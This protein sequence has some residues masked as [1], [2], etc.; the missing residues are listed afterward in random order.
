L[1]YIFEILASIDI[2]IGQTLYIS[3]IQLK[4]VLHTTGLIR[5]VDNFLS[6]IENFS[7]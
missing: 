4:K 6:S 1:M 2:V 7:F 5:S 3:M